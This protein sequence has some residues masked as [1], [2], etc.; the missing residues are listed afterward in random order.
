MRVC[1]IGSPATFTFALICACSPAFATG[2][3]V[4]LASQFNADAVLRYSGGTLTSP[5][6]SYDDF[7][8]GGSVDNVMMTQSAANQLSTAQGLTNPAPVGINDTGFYPATGARLYDVQF[9]FTN[10]TPT[11]TN[12]L[13]RSNASGNFTFSVPNTQYSQFAIF[14]SGGSGNSTLTITL[15]YT[16]GSAGLVSGVTLPD[17]YSGSPANTAAS[18]AGTVFA[19]TPAM[20][21]AA[22]YLLPAGGY[23]VPNAGNGAFIYGINLAPDPTR[24]LTSVNVAYASGDPGYSVVNL[25][26]AAGASAV[27]SSP[28]TAPAPGT[29]LLL[30]SGIAFAYWL[31]LRRRREA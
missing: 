6:I 9:G 16:T 19:L 26:T 30:L 22:L 14:G 24:V 2:I 25:F 11:G 18:A 20:A 23:Q 27:T 12:T 29:W 10:T 5:S 17:W 13:F 3:Q 8:P 15:N 1:R 31:Y 4:S 7:A 28:S 21:R